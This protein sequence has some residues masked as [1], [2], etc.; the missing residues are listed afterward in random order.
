[1]ANAIQPGSRVTLHYTLSLADDTVVDSTREAEPITFQIGSGALIE[2]LERQLIGLRTGEHRRFEISAAE[3]QLPASAE[4]IQTMARSDFPAELAIE[5]GQVLGFVMPSGEEVPGL[6]V[7]ISDTEVIVDFSHP[8][9]GR[10]LIFDVE[11][12][13]VEPG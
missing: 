3:S 8:L 12:L 2:M 9:A 10:D 6:I 5:T 4:A 11:I 13:A 1:M 7:S